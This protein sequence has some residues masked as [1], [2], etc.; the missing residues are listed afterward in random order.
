MTGCQLQRDLSN[1]VPVA[2]CGTGL[3]A[4]ELN[5]NGHF[6]IRIRCNAD[7][8]RSHCQPAIERFGRPKSITACVALLVEVLDVKLAI[9]RIDLVWTMPGHHVLPP[10]QSELIDRR[11]DRSKAWYDT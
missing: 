7:H 8:V 3:A 11:T 4:A 2:W 10:A 9:A 5:G 1:M 6:P